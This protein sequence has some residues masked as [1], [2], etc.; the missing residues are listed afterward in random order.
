M[1][2]NLFNFL[3]NNSTSYKN[4]FIKCSKIFKD[5]LVN[6]ENFFF[7]TLSA[8]YQKTV[9]LKKSILKQKLH[10]NILVIGMGGSVLGS[11]MFSSFFGLDKNY[12][13]LDNLNN[14]IVNNFIKKDLSKFSIFIISK[15]GKTLETL[16][17]CNII[18]NNFNKRKKNISKNFIVISER[19]NILSNFA[20]KNNLMFF[21][22]NINLSGRYSVLSEVGLLMFNL[23][24][25]KI[26]QGINS[27]LKKGLNKNLISN[28]ATLLTLIKKSKIDTHVSLIY[29]HNLLSYGYWHQQ[30]LAESIGK[31]G[32]DFTPIISECPKDHHS[33]MQLYL[34]G[35][36]N[37]FFTFFKTIN[38]KLDQPIKDYFDQKFKRNSL[39][40]I[41]D[42]QFNATINVFKK[43]LIPFRVVLIDQ[44]KPIKSFISLIVYS[45]L[46]TAIL[47][48]ALNLNP[49][50]QPAV[51]EIKKETYSLLG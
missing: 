19:N 29:S 15:S 18:L 20:R 41:I 44:K 6:K 7:N 49:F 13:F 39:N 37:K 48:K 33:I 35:K 17:N 22:H 25:K 16:T 2:I 38:N 36:K 43:N 42:S 31:K 28:A 8:E 51:E 3:K 32:K 47:C 40:N 45:M 23:D 14:S 30:L 46:E 9:S 4:N 50:N 34:D 26:I 1:K 5:L 24:Y 11:K 27:V 12:Y 10:K 21:E